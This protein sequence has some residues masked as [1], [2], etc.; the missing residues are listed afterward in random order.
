M[1]RENTFNVFQVVRGLRIS[2]TGDA[3]NTL[4]GLGPAPAEASL[5]ALLAALETPAELREVL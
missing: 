2:A 5:A 4:R 3:A 1:E